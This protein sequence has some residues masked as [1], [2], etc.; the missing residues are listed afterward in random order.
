[1]K[2]D[3]GTIVTIVVVLLCYVRLMLLQ[4]GKARRLRSLVEREKKKGKNTKKIEAEL[5]K[6]LGV[7]V[8]SMPLITFGLVMI[9]AGGIIRAVPSVPAEFSQYWWMLVSSGVL[10]SAFAIR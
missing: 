5:Q 6:N 1:M 7:K 3:F 4:W 8:T 9:L 2:L 10:M